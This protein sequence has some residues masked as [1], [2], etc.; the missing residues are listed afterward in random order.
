MCCPSA[1]PRAR[2]MRSRSLGSSR[3]PIPVGGWRPTEAAMILARRCPSSRLPRVSATVDRS[4]STT[5]PTTKRTTTT[6]RAVSRRVPAG[7][8]SPPPM[9]SGTAPTS[10]PVARMNPRLL[11]YAHHDEC[12]KQRRE[13]PAHR[14]EPT[15][16]EPASVLAWAKGREP[17]PWH[18]PSLGAAIRGGRSRDSDHDR[19]VCTDTRPH[20]A[21]D[22]DSWWFEGQWRLCRRRR[23]PLSPVRA[24]PH[25][26]SDAAVGMVSRVHLSGL[27]SCA[28]G[29]GAWWSFRC[30]A[31]GRRAITPMD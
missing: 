2:A 8:P 14:G 31:C 27:R 16:Q 25:C 23:D 13:R 26:Q 17:T 1:A 29:A 20:L 18:L 7:E 5:C 28:G 19:P 11:E 24:A 22:G 21:W 30:E 9:A 6:A 15:G 4:G 12:A 3:C 10:T